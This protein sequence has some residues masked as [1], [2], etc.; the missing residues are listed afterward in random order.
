MV[1]LDL[2]RGALLA[3]SPRVE[4]EKMK[5][6][7]FVATLALASVARGQ[8]VS[9]Q[10]GQKI[11]GPMFNTDATFEL[12][13]DPNHVFAETYYRAVPQ[14]GFWQ[15]VGS[16]DLDFGNS[17][18]SPSDVT[19]WVSD[20]KTAQKYGVPTVDATG[21]V[22]ANGRVGMIVPRVEGATGD[23]LYAGNEPLYAG[24][25]EASQRYKN[26]ANPEVTLADLRAIEEG[27]QA[28]RDH[29]VPIVADRLQ[30]DA[31]GHVRVPR[32]E[33][34]PT[35]DGGD[36]LPLPPSTPQSK[37][38][39]DHQAAIINA[40]RVEVRNVELVS[41]TLQESGIE[42]DPKRANA[43][44]A[45]M[46]SDMIESS[47]HLTGAAPAVLS[48]DMEKVADKLV[49]GLQPSFCAP[50]IDTLVRNE[51]ANVLLQKDHGPIVGGISV[52]DKEHGRSSLE[53]FLVKE[54]G[55]VE[56]GSTGNDE[57]PKGT[58]TYTPTADEAARIAADMKK[59]RALPAPTAADKTIP[60]GQA[61]FVVEY[62]D[63]QGKHHSSVVNMSYISR[64]KD[65]FM[66]FSKL[67]EAIANKVDSN[68]MTHTFDRIK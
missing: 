51:L 47:K 44:A 56:F 62:T 25:K 17:N 11:A 14:K 1:L 66:D 20:L 49:T 5:A 61:T 26:Y 28:A 12:K 2:G 46:L 22:T 10:L 50:C 18:G 43:L 16:L 7:I 68:G 60:P 40:V 31:S 32:V 6:Q 23:P 67:G 55:T 29:G 54:D 35:A 64:N 19:K 39:L 52:I 24:N 57:H 63:D 33:R 21:P 13:N 30:I 9:N 15:R 36:G 65:A 41:K 58:F 8:D 27:T 53:T 37:P 48:P 59:L 45:Q 38:I 4:R 42:K 34:V 3:R